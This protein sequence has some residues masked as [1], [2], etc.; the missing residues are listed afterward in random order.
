MTE[1]RFTLRFPLLH[2]RS[3]ISD[4]QD[5]CLLSFIFR[6]SRDIPRKNPHADETFDPS[7]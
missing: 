6:F 3:L 4:T 5:D 7:V 2:A 1:T